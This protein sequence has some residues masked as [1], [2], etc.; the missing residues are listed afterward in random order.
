MDCRRRA[1]W[2]CFGLVL[3]K[4]ENMKTI[5]FFAVVLFVCAFYGC[6][7]ASDKMFAECMSAGVQSQAQCE[8][9]AYYR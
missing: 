7:M 3:V 1:K 2:D 4:G 8:F 6:K 5:L 9:E